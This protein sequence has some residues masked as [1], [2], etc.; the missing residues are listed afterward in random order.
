MPLPLMN[1]GPLINQLAKLLTVVAPI[2]RSITDSRG[3]KKDIKE[4]VELQA[5][6]LKSLEEQLTIVKT[7]LSNI[8]KSL[9][10]WAWATVSVGILS[11]IS[12]TVAILKK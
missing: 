12:V 11:I 3:Q 2:I 7:V 9:Q 8:E 1:I 10:L 5:R 6:V 4:A